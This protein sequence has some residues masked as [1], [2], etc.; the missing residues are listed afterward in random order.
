LI[1]DEP[2]VG[3]D[4]LLRRRYIWNFVFLDLGSA[5]CLIL[6]RFHYPRVIFLK[7][8]LNADWMFYCSIWDHLVQQ[9][10]DH[11]RTVIITTHYIEEARQADA[12]RT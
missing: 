8:L 7:S 6:F 4:P 11:G 9:S 10:V 3:V 5:D 1:L 12:V 2:T